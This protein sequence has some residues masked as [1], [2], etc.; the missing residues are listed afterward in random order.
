[1]GNP[2]FT[3]SPLKVEVAHGEPHR[4]IVIRNIITDKVSKGLVFQSAVRHEVK[5]ELAKLYI[6]IITGRCYRVPLGM[7]SLF[8]LSKA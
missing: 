5:V 6:V 7:R 2:Y 1:M 3:L 8:C 4:I